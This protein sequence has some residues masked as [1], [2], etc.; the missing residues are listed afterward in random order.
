MRVRKYV[1]I[2]NDRL[3]RYLACNKR[4]EGVSL[5]ETSGRRTVGARGG[6]SAR[7]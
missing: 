2:D 4:V 3:A 7:V 6:R 5:G 1:S